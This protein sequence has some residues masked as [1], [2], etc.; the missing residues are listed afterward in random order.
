MEEG[1]WDDEGYYHR[2]VNG[3]D[4]TYESWEAYQECITDSDE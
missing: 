4:T 3:C 2:V 1:W